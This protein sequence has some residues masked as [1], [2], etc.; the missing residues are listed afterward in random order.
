MLATFSNRSPGEILDQVLF[1]LD[2]GPGYVVTVIGVFLV[3]F[4]WRALMKQAHPFRAALSVKG[5]PLRYSAFVT[6]GIPL[7]GPAISRSVTLG[8]SGMVQSFLQ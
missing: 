8:Q 5:Q 2:T 7:D 4:A 6:C 1:Y 3:W